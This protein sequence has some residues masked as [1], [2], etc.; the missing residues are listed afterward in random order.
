MDVITVE[1]KA[2]KELE[3]KINAIADY[4][5]NKQESENINEDEIWVDSYEVCTFLK[6]SDKTLQR[7]RVS[8]TIA[9]SNIRGRYFYKIG[10]IKRM[11]EERLVRS[12]T[13]CLNDLITNHKLHVKERRNLRK[14]K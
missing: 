12:N 1:S 13:D 9:Y 7:L 6:I 4:V 3:A 10:E 14:D 8:G 2:F 11:L 5:L